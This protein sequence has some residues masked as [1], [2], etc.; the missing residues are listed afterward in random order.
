MVSTVRFRSFNSPVQSD[1]ISALGGQPVD[2]NAPFIDMVREGQLR[3]PDPLRRVVRRPLL[4]ERLAR[5]AVDEPLERHR[6]AAGAAQGTVRDGEVVRDEVHLRVAGLGEVDLVRVRDRD[7]AAADL[8]DLLAGR[9]GGMLA[10][11]RKEDGDG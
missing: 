9:H 1:T 8:E 5:R 6:P 11:D 10:V 4:E 3:G 7:L 2:A